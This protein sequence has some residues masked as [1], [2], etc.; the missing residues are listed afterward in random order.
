MILSH[1]N[2]SL[3]TVL[4]KA[5]DFHYNILGNDVPSLQ[6][7][8]VNIMEKLPSLFEFSTGGG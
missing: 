2:Q 3:N 7:G 8:V 4:A 1:T 5:T 6:K